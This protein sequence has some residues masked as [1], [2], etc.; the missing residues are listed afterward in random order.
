LPKNDGLGGFDVTE[1]ACFPPDDRDDPLNWFAVHVR[2]R[3]EFQV[4]EKL[5]GS[6][7]DTFLPTVERLR[8]WKDRNKRIRFPLFPGYLFVHVS[9]NRHVILSVL[10]TKGVVRLLGQE[11]GDPEP[12][13]DGQIHALKRLIESN[14]QLDPY[15]FLRE[16]QRVRIAR[17]PLEGIEGLLVRKKDRH[18]LVLSVDI[19]RQSTAVTIETTDVEAV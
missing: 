2:S 3:H 19:L 14:A 7:I 1:T 4:Y 6:G 9:S 17:G 15:P 8:K 10:K 11:P 18:M 5:T 13:P 12:V 16:G